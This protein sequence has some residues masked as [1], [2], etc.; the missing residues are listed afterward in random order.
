MLYGIE[1]YKSIKRGKVMKDCLDWGYEL[2][3]PGKNNWGQTK[4]GNG[5]ENEQGKKHRDWTDKA[6]DR[7]FKQARKEARKKP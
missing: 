3:E 7:A 4:K 1:N 5:N 6:L 2:V